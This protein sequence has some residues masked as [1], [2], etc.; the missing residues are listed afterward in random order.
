MDLL[1]LLHLLILLISQ[2]GNNMLLPNCIYIQINLYILLMH[3][4]ICI[5]IYMY[6]CISDIYTNYII[7]FLAFCALRYLKLYMYLHV[8][9][10][11]CVQFICMYNMYIFLSIKCMR[12]IFC[13]FCFLC[14]YC[15]SVFFFFFP[16]CF[17]VVKA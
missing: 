12:N 13:Y 14:F 4:Y 17:S 10:N 2:N 6:I 11:M 16:C 15:I 1:L 5:Y 7:C 9:T 3:T 8:C